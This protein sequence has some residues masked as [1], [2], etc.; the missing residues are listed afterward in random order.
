MAGLPNAG[1][2]A[3]GELTTAASWYAKVF[4][5]INDAI[6]ALG[7]PADS[8]WQTPAL[9]NGWAN[10]ATGWAPAQYRLR[11][12]RVYLQGRI[13]SGAVGVA[14]TLPVG[15]RPPI[16]S[17]FVVASN[18]GTA[19]VDVFENGAVSVISYGTGGSN[20]AVSLSGI[21]CLLVP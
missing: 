21:S 10:I 20:A 1:T 3:S 19:R 7:V 14:F 18:A 2:F 15:Y 6:A 11:D 8:G 5:P 17:L 9:L 16:P 12:G 13:R 4:S